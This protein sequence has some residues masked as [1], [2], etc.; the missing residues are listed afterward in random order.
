[1]DTVVTSGILSLRP[2]ADVQITEIVE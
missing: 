2:G 1:M